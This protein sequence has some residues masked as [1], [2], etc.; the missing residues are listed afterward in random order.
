MLSRRSL[1]LVAAA[2]LLLAAAAVLLGRS[3][4]DAGAAH[5]VIAPSGRRRDENDRGKLDTP[6]G[7]GRRRPPATP[8][9]HRSG[10]TQLNDEELPS[11]SDAADDSLPSQQPLSPSQRSAGEHPLSPAEEAAADDDGPAMAEEHVAPD[12]AA[13]KEPYSALPMSTACPANASETATEAASRTPSWRLTPALACGVCRRY[14]E[15]CRILNGQASASPALVYAVMATTPLDW[16]MIAVVLHEV[17][18]LVK[19]VLIVESTQ[20]HSLREKPKNE[21]LLKTEYAVRFPLCADKLDVRVYDPGLSQF[22]SGW[23]VEKRQRRHAARIL[24][25]GGP[26]KKAAYGLR[27]GDIAIVNLDLDEVLPR[28]ALIRLKYCL[29]RMARRI[30]QRWKMRIVDWN[31]WLRYQF[32]LIAFR[33]RWPKLSA[34]NRV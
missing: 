29:P 26:D 32:Q 12:G 25:E 34:A 6:S 19:K 14:N 17:C 21:T 31:R 2:S 13:I 7:V 18:P 33:Y 9:L 28:R 24:L 5:D 20:S 16:P 11:P 1:A 3:E 10:D 4:T 27:R 8:A 15:H 22:A 23:F 30:K